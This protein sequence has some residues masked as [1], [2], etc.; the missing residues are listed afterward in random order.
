VAVEVDKNGYV[1]T[2]R[3]L[4]APSLSVAQSASKAATQWSFKRY[5]LQNSNR[6]VLLSGLLTFYFEVKNGKGVV[7]SPADTGYVGH[8]P[9]AF[10]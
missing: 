5:Y 1:E 8:W 2:A 9:K 10:R 7:T 6:E 3:V 4:Q